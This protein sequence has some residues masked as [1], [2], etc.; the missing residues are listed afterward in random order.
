MS[1]LFDQRDSNVAS[2]DSAVTSPAPSSTSSRGTARVARSAARSTSSAGTAISD[3]TARSG[4]SGRRKGRRLH[5]DDPAFATDAKVTP[6]LLRGDHVHQEQTHPSPTP[7]PSGH[8]HQA[9]AAEELNLDLESLGLED[10][11]IPEGQLQKM[12][13]VGSGGFKDVYVGKLRSRMK[14]AIAEFRGQLGEMDIK[15]LKLLADFKHPNIV[16]FLGVCI[17]EDRRTPIMMVSELCENG[18]LFDYI[19]NVPAPSKKVVVS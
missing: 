19:R 1:L 11:E 14:V 5:A 13:K 17:P 18:D 12:E 16:K 6:T 8:A 4:G 3:A 9:A 2:D 15:E 7:P 10:K